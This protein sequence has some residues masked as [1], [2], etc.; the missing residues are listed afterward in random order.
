MSD[1]TDIG[2]ALKKGGHNFPDREA[3]NDIRAYGGLKGFDESLQILAHEWLE[4]SVTKVQAEANMA[5]GLATIIMGIIF[6]QIAGGI[7]SLMSQIGGG[8]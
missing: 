4:E 6:S 3:I 2:T 8:L 7:F 1:G 5:K